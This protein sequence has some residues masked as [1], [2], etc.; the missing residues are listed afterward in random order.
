MKFAQARL[1]ALGMSMLAV[2]GASLLEAAL[3]IDISETGVFIAAMTAFLGLCF[4][5]P[6]ASGGRRGG[7]PPD[8]IG[9]SE[10]RKA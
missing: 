4:R 5:A 7:R 10:R 6:P 9:P 2:A 1:F 8:Q 3:G